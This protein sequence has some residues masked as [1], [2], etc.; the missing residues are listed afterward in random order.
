MGAMASTVSPLFI[1]PF[2]Q[3]QL[4]KTS[5]LHITGLCAENSRVTDEFPAQMAI[6]AENVSI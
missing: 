3:T 2:I 4:K 6:N 5:K 1:Q